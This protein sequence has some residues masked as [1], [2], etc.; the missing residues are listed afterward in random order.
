MKTEGRAATDGEREETARLARHN[1]ALI[2]DGVAA[3]HEA[4]V[5]ALCYGELA[6]LDDAARD[7][8]MAWLERRLDWSPQP[9]PVGERRP[10]Q[11]R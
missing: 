11:P 5:M 1:A 2:D 10:Q 9:A 4:R 8:A 6:R 7:R 3:E